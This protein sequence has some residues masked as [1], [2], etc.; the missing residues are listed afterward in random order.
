MIEDTH[1]RVINEVVEM[2][3]LTSWEKG[4]TTAKEIADKLSP[5]LTAI[6]LEGTT[7]RLCAM[8]EC[9]RQYD[10]AEP[11]IEPGW[12]LCT[13]IDRPL[14]PGHS[15]LLKEGH[16]PRWDHGD[17]K[18]VGSRLTCECEWRSTPVRHR[19]SGSEQWADH[20]YEVAEQ[21]AAYASYAQSLNEE[22]HAFARA[23][24]A[25]RRDTESE[26]SP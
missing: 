22:D 7:R 6:V 2:V 23:L 11:G 10:A 9:W 13:P 26:E 4:P 8:L 24:R 15:W 14:C 3:W 17:G 25:H 21:R 5:L 18:V 20:A 1:D 12:Y 16:S 19:A